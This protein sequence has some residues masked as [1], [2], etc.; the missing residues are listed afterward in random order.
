MKRSGQYQHIATIWILLFCLSLAA[1]G[2]SD[3]E[4]VET[5]PEEQAVA[6][7]QMDVRTWY[8]TPRSAQQQ[9][10]A[11][12]PMQQPMTAQPGMVY[13]PVPVQQPQVIIV[14]P[15][16]Q[17]R[18]PQPVQQ[19]AYQPQYGQPMQQQ[20]YPQQIYPQQ[21]VPQQQYVP[22]Y[23]TQFQY[24]QRPWGETGSY[25]QSRTAQPASGGQ[26]QTFGV[27]FGTPVP[28]AGG[29]YPGWGVSPQGT[30]P[31]NPYPGNVW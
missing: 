13:Q 24:G 6:V 12:M 5:Q 15:A 25:S 26:Q 29:A 9:Q 16:Y 20:G 7:P 3:D 21:S 30:F 27:P 23:Q 1:T 10:P 28:P 2:C 8:P 14:Q 18:Y 17:P 19:Q 11:M 22:Q 31:G 4:P